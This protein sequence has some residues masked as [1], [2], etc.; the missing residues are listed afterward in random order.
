MYKKSTKKTCRFGRIKPKGIPALR[1][2]AP[3]GLIAS[4]IIGIALQ[5]T[6]IFAHNTM[7]A[8]FRALLI[9]ACIAPA[10]IALA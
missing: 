9:G 3:I 8:W 7:N 2:A 5:A 6:P 10:T 4:A 1:L